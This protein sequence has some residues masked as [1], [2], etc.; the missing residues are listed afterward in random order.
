MFRDAEKAIVWAVNVKCKFILDGS[1]VNDM[2]G[3]PRPS[4]RNELL[5]GLSP[6]EAHLQAEQIFKH[7]ESLS[8]GACR[9]YL[10]ARYCYVERFDELMQRVFFRLLYSGGIH[11]R[12]VRKVVLKYLGV[13]IGLREIRE[14]LHCDRNKVNYL[15]DRVYT[16]L[17]TV[18]HQAISDV[19]EKFTQAGLI[20]NRNS[21]VA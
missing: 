2:C 20:E 18:H 14:A 12:D 4:T 1:S 15:I 13:K 9:D 16:I 21:A 19:E 11:N 3:K 17:D 8:D 6:Q 7:I 5:M 10:Y